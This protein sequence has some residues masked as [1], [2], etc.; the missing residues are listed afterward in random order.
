MKLKKVKMSDIARQ[1]GVSNVTV[2]KALADKD[3]V[4]EKLRAEIKRVAK[5]M[6]YVFTANHLPVGQKRIGVLIAKEYVEQEYSFYWNLYKYI[7]TE[8]QF[9]KVNALIE[10]IDEKQTSSLPMFMHEP[11]MMGIIVLGSLST[12]YLRSLKDTGMTIVL[13][14]TY[15]SEVNLTHIQ[16]N[17]YNDSYRITDLLI[18]K[19]Y[20]DLGFVGSIHAITAIQDRYLGF[21][22]AL[23]SHKLNVNEKWLIEDRNG[24]EFKRQ[25]DLPDQ[26]PQAFVCNCDQTA[27]YFMEYLKKAG[28]RIP[29]DV[30]IVGYYDYVYSQLCQPP[31][32]TVHVD[33]PRMAKE[34]VRALLDLKQG[35][36]ESRHI[37][38]NGEIIERKSIKG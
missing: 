16:S 26:M 1:V 27:Y 18:Q 22:K 37:I 28:Y 6:G 10:V 15:D 20:T 36:N 12:D 11:E 29:E 7:V 4:S 38:V 3:G 8:L 17:N 5:E 31:L 24:L 9:Y 21:C 25:F 19:G 32:T 2:S 35:E 33:L 23:V 30:A 34:A 13:V 14:D